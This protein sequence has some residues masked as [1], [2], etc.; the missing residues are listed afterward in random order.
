MA[1]KLEQI[2]TSD[3]SVPRTLPFRPRRPSRPRSWAVIG[4]YAGF[5][6]VFALVGVLA[7]LANLLLALRGAS[8]RESS[9]EGGHWLPGPR[10]HR[11]IELKT[12]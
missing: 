11:P 4:L 6:A 9:A 10:A 8:P 3:A 12:A 1:N 5:T 2:K 7:W